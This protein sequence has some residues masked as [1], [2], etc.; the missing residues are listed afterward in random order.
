[1]QIKFENV[2]WPAADSSALS[3]TATI[4]QIASEPRLLG[5]VGIGAALAQGGPLTHSI[6]ETCGFRAFNCP[7]G[8]H[9][10]FD[11]RI[12]RLMPGMYPAIPGWHCD[13]WPRPSYDAQ[14]DP[15]LRDLDAYHITCFVDTFDGDLSATEYLICPLA[16]EWDKTTPLWQQVHR[17]VETLDAPR[18]RMRGGVPYQFNGDL[19]HRATPAKARGWRYWFRFSTMHRMPDKALTPG[20]EQI[21]VLSEENG[22]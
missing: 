18:A 10:V 11:T 21:Y 9:P 5:V 16:M 7:R 14:P 17:E 19:I 4:E 3:P 15:E 1:M 8:L 20:P 6:I 12:Q 22:W 13:D 2:C